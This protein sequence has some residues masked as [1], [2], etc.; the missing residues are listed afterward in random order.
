MIPLHSCQDLSNGIKSWSHHDTSGL[1][2][3]HA[4]LCQVREDSEHRAELLVPS[5]QGLSPAEH[6]ESGQLRW[7]TPS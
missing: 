7:S 4:Q 1:P 3:D 5:C 6:P 2:Y